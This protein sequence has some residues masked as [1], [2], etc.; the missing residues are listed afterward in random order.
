[1]IRQIAGLV[2]D[3]LLLAVEKPQP[4]SGAADA[5]RLARKQW[6]A[7]LFRVIEAELKTRRAGIYR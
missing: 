1:M 7:V 3:N 5:F 4:C 6:R 2:T